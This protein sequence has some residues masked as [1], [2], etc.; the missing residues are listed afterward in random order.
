[1]VVATN[2]THTKVVHTNSIRGSVTNSNN[3][4]SRDSSNNAFQM[5]P[6]EDMLWKGLAA[7]CFGPNWDKPMKDEEQTGVTDADAENGTREHPPGGGGKVGLSSLLADGGPDSMMMM[8]L[9]G[10]L[11]GQ[12]WHAPFPD[13]I[14][15]FPVTCQ[16][17]MANLVHASLI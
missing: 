11:G 5:D 7:F 12:V 2:S 10:M 1:M 14:I 6:T 15:A 17:N 3:T 4:N 8:D 9:G 16:H 13:E